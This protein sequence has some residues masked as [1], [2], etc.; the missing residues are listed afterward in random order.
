MSG[1][2]AAAADA[3]FEMPK[4]DTYQRDPESA[5][6]PRV[7]DYGL[8]RH[9]FLAALSYF[10]I[11]PEDPDFFTKVRTKYKRDTLKL[12]NSPGG[13]NRVSINAHITEDNKGQIFILNNLYEAVVDFIDAGGMDH[14]YSNPHPANQPG[15]SMDTSPEAKYNV[16][17]SPWRPYRRFR[18][19]GYPQLNY[20]QSE[21]KLYTKPPRKRY[22]WRKYHKRKFR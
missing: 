12:H 10:Q 21:Q 1:A 14:Y 22:Y 7:I 19:R 16:R 13:S 20:W 8:L 11:D 2:R 4:S 15:E 18:L 17:R 6:I 5:Y 9:N 3:E